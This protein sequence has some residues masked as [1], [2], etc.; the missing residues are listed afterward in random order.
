M[1][2][3]VK[4]DGRTNSGYGKVT[5]WMRK[6]QVYTKSQVV[7]QFKQ[8][9]LSDKAAMASAVVLLS[10]RLESKRGDSRGNASNPWGHQAYNEKLAK[11]EGQERKF[12]FRIR[13]KALEAKV[14][15]VTV[16]KAEKLESSLAKA[17]KEEIF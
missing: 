15:S 5:A 14:R 17:E 6:A 10:P 9:G 13:T 11:V 12:R 16:S 3:Q 7:E 8:L 1:S 2:K 4:L